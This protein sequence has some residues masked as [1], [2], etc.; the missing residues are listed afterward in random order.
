M[1][2]ERRQRVV[3]FCIY[4]GWGVHVLGGGGGEGGCVVLW[5][6]QFTATYSGMRKPTLDCEG[7]RQQ[8]PKIKKEKGGGGSICIGA[9]RLPWRI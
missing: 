7:V 8:I 4:P 1:L 3:E 6:F 9:V 2:V 5:L